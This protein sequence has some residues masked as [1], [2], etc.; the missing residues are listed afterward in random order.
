MFDGRIYRAAFLPLLLVL[1]IVGF[2]LRG[3]PAGLSSTL[4]P[5]ALE[6]AQAYATLG[7][8]A[9]HYPDRRPGSAGDDALARYVA[10]AMAHAGGGAGGGFRVSVHRFGAATIA[11]GQTLTTVVGVRPGS[12]GESPIAIVAHRDAA[13]RGSAAELSGTAVLLELAHVFAQSETRRTIVL[14][15]TSGGSGGDAGVRQFASSASRP[16]DAA[17]VLG[18]LAGAQAHKPFV[19]PFAAGAGAAPRQLTRTLDAAISQ[20]VG[21]SPG[22]PG[23][24]AQLAHL[25]FPLNTAEQAPLDSA[26]IPAALVQVSGERQ[27]NAGE[28]ISE[29]RLQS[30]GRAVLGAVYA[31]DEGPDV[32]GGMGASVQ[33]AGKVLPGWGVRLLV[34]ALLL[35]PLLACGDALARVRRRRQPLARPL[36]WIASC[37]APLFG[38]AL[39]AMLL[40]ALG[41]LP[42]PAGQPSAQAL[43][44]I[45]S[46]KAAT[47]A[48]ALVLVLTLLAW[49]ALA[50]RLGLALLPTEEGA[51][52]ALM[53]VLLGVCLLVWAVNPFACLLL[54]P[55]AHACLLVCSSQRRH[56]AL[57]LG[58]VAVSMAPL[59]LQLAV[60]ARELSLGPVALAQ[61]AVLLLAGGGV[62]LLGAVLWSLALGCVLATL[63]LVRPRAR[64]SM[65]GPPPGMGPLPE[66]ER[67]TT[68]GPLSYAGPGSLGGTESALRR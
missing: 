61:S 37:A 57:R 55:A 11:G 17:I 60:Y 1:A 45:G 18:D 63:L 22:E 52:V 27:P 19:V 3:R 43:A 58:V 50:R 32:K 34:F 44:T 10:W 4:A 40:G 16:L 41:V 62:G 9:R 53:L 56:A 29:A 59:A 36:L 42:A 13:L 67:I 68:R 54:V 20:E 31:L 8:L 33:I 28:A 48:A 24:A 35:A 12:S 2:S 5:D 23:F 46:L 6:G 39:F 7:W 66:L 21:T 26:G 49:P 25:S 51:G 65:G 64:E 30:F 14:V 47:A 15:S 38:T